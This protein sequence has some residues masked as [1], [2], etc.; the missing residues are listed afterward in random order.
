MIE[1]L[2]DLIDLKSFVTIAITLTM[3]YMTI[4]GKMDIKDFTSIAL[5]I[6]AFYFTK[7]KKVE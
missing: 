3:C 4:T 5:M 1:K 6:Y 7:A 2:K